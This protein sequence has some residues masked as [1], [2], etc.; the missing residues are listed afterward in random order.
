VERQLA[1]FSASIRPIANSDC[2]FYTSDYIAVS[3]LPDRYRKIIVSSEIM[4]E[5]NGAF[6][7]SNLRACTGTPLFQ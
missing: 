2:L 1:P 6:V 4:T 5:A 7:G 3:S